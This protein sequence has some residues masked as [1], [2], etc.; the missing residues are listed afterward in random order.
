VSA[1][2]GQAWPA[3]DDLRPGYLLLEEQSLEVETVPRHVAD[4]GHTTFEQLLRFVDG[5]H[6]PHQFRLGDDTDLLVVDLRPATRE[7]NMRVDQSRHDVVPVQVDFLHIL[8]APVLRHR[9]H[10]GDASLSDDH[11]LVVD[12]RAAVPVDDTD[13]GE[14]EVVCHLHR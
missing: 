14:C 9:E 10:G 4:G 5:A 8:C 12:G 11:G 6:R 2:T 7:V 3:G 13:R 1:G